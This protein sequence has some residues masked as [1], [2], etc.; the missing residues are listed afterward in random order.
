MDELFCAF[1][2]MRQV[3]VVTGSKRQ[4][5]NHW[6]TTGVP[7]RHWKPLIAAARARRIKGITLETLEA[8]RPAKQRAA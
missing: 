1:G 5:V 4:A 8:T 3:M 7:F 2:G 6:R